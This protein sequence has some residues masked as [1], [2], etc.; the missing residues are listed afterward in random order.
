[1]LSIVFLVHS[2]VMALPGIINSIKYERR[3]LQG[4]AKMAGG[5]FA[6]ALAAF[7]GAALLDRECAC[8]FRYIG[9][10]HGK[11]GEADA[12]RAAYR[13][14]LL[15]EDQ[16]WRTR[17]LLSDRMRAAG[18]PQAMMIIRNTAPPFRAEQ[19]NWAWD[20]LDPAPVWELDV[21]GAD[22]GYL[23]GF[24]AAETEHGYQGD[25]T[26]R[27]TTDHAYVRL[28][29]TGYEGHPGQ[30]RGP[31][32]ARL[33]LRWHA[34]AAPGLTAQPPQE[35]VRVLVNGREIA[36]PSVGAGW[37]DTAL[38]LPDTGSDSGTDGSGHFV[39]ELLTPTHR[40]PQP[41]NRM[42]G[43]AVDRISIEARPARTRR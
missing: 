37:Q 40:A 39:I 32:N 17:A 42:L 5:D 26:F 16:D 2:G 41:D 33:L 21:G 15:P 29:A 9:M 8:L 25:I 3:Y 36:Q 24:E 1:M 14:A 22:I 43:V 30:D 13:A 6:G 28:W 23:K 38:D 27:W 34:F 31:G 7:S 19:L 20:N 10:A 18:D 11:L 12:E 35:V 4:K